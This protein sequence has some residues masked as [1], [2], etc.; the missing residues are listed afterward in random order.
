MVVDPVTPRCRGGKTPAAGP[1]SASF[2]VR[3]LRRV[4]ATPSFL[5][6]TILV[7]QQRAPSAVL[8]AVDDGH[9]DRRVGVSASGGSNMPRTKARG[10]HAR[11][12][13]V[14]VG[15][16]ALPRSDRTHDLLRISLAALEIASG[17]QAATTAP[18][19]FAGLMTPN[20]RADSAAVRRRTEAASNPPFSQSTVSSSQGLAQAGTPF[21]RL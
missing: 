7:A 4:G 12:R 5:S 13:P 14:D 20:H 2:F 15:F 19:R 9:R 1:T 10:Q 8:G 18:R 17:A 6:S 21:T 3:L 16:R 11:E